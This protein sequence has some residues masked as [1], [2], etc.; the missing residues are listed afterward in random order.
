MTPLCLRCQP[1]PDDARGHE[2]KSLP[3][4]AAGPFS[5]PRRLSFRAP[6]H[7]QP[8]SSKT[9]IPSSIGRVF[10]G[11]LF[12]ENRISSFIGSAFAGFTGLGRASERPT[13]QKT[14]R[15]IYGHAKK[16]ARRLRA[17][18]D[19]LWWLSKGYA[20]RVRRGAWATVVKRSLGLRAAAARRSCGTAGVHTDVA[21]AGRAS[22]A[23][24][25]RQAGQVV[26][27][28]GLVIELGTPKN[29]P[30]T[31]HI[32]KV[33]TGFLSQKKASHIPHR[34][35][36]TGFL[37]HLVVTR[38]GH[39]ACGHTVAGCSPPGTSA[40]HGCRMGSRPLG[41]KPSVGRV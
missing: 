23:Q 16:L 31:F 1:W 9:P 33:F 36:F 19:R 24:P 2:C 35:S 21:C 15:G 6:W 26:L 13:S 4:D 25:R 3:V 32:G 20:Q 12:H 34:S 5:R 41:L 10:T 29:T 22:I 18:P 8:T 30:I 37:G 27:T 38:R 11:F 28:S 7:I 14:G 39:P 17:S 40:T